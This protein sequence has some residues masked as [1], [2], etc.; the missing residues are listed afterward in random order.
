MMLPHS[1]DTLTPDAFEENRV[2]FIT[3]YPLPAEPLLPSVLPDWV[4]TAITWRFSRG[5][6]PLSN[7]DLLEI[8]TERGIRTDYGHP[9]TLRNLEEQFGTDHPRP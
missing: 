1:G 6:Q 3:S 8:L 9:I 2:R 5:E 7:A 4:A